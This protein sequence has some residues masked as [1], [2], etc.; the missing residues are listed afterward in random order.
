MKRGRFLPTLLFM[1]VHANAL[2]CRA[3]AMNRPK[4][5]QRLEH[6]P[7]H[8]RQK[9]PPSLLSRDPISSNNNPNRPRHLPDIQKRLISPAFM[10]Q[11]LSS[12]HLGYPSFNT[13]TIV[14]PLNFIDGNPADKS[15]IV[16]QL[17]SLVLLLH[18]RRRKNQSR[19]RGRLIDW[20]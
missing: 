6:S 19:N 2:N 18:S 20:E 4:L 5:L 7:Q 14:S 10:S 1:C 9:P 17:I 11:G 13:P 12:V 8:L 15:N 3:K 16:F